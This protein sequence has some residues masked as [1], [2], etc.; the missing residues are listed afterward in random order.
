[1]TARG[2]PRD[3]IVAIVIAAFLLGGV[4]LDSFGP[5]V[6]ADPAAASA[7]PGFTARAVF[8]P[9]AL[10]KPIGRKSS[11][12][13]AGR[14]TVTAAARGDRP[15]S[16][17]I[18]PASDERAELAPGSILELKPPSAEAAD[19]VGYGGVVDATVVTSIDEPVS[20]VGAASCAAGASTR[21]F[22]PEGN[23]T[24][25]HD[26]RLLVYNPFPD[27]AVVRIRF[28][29]PAGERSK[30]SLADVAVPSERSITVA[31]KDFIL[32]Q[33]VLGATVT[34]VRGR[35]AAWRLT[36]ARPEESP[37]GIQLTLGTTGPAEKWYFP[38][39]AV[40]AG[41][42]ER[43]S[44]LNPGGQEATVDVT[45][46]TGSRSI[47]APGLTDIS[48]PAGSTAAVQVD[49]RALPGARGGAS[50]IV[51]SANGVPIVVERTVFYATEDMDG[52]ASEIGSA[53]PGRRWFLGPATSRPDTDSVVLLNTSGNEVTVSL[54]LLRAE[55]TP[56]TPAALQDLEIAGGSRLRVPLGEITRGEARAVLVDATGPVVAERFSYSGGA[57]DVAS[58]MG[59]L[60]D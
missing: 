5:K 8:C 49:Q 25:T 37:S 2:G 16:V 34:A 15:V 55:G 22:F 24:V 13:L 42:L 53:T 50:A 31:L 12:A 28:F 39:G 1:M 7:E 10:G 59:T 52:V 47:P 3:G 11:R 29:T 40:G 51:S 18:E 27:E 41:Y 9:S 20:G 14:M 48:V 60:L 17:G 36:V 35:V 33:R 21:W 45:L 26:E 23:S 57:G 43:F 54:T 58:L 46:V 30:A 32:E 44:I 56:L 6:S 19:V 38:E 4:A